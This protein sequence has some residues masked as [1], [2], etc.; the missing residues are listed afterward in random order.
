MFRW[1]A[2]LILGV[3]VTA[4]PSAQVPAVPVPLQ[5]SL[6]FRIMTYDRSLPTRAAGGLVVGVAFQGRLRASALAAEEALQQTPPSGFPYPVRLVAID[7]D[8]TADLAAA[9]ADCDVLYVAPLRAYRVAD[10][11]AAARARGI[12]TVTGI[13]EY[14]DEGLAIGVDLRGDRPEILVNLAAARAERADF[15]AA[16]LRLATIR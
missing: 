8:S 11:S 14:L 4:A 5:F 2:V 6:F 13:P 3:L 12:L 1:A 16:F 15:T 10:I 9:L 7:L